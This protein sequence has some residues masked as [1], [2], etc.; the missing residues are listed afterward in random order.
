MSEIKLH[1]GKDHIYLIHHH[2]FK[3]CLLHLDAEKLVCI[4]SADFRAV[5]WAKNI[6]GIVAWSNHSESS[7]WESMLLEIAVHVPYGQNAEISKEGS[8]HINVKKIGAKRSVLK[9]Q[10]IFLR[11]LLELF[12]VF[13]FFSIFSMCRSINS[14]SLS[15]HCVSILR[16]VF[17]S[18]TG[19][20]CNII[21]FC[22]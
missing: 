6:G 14:L 7:C 1:E 9:C 20:M 18:Y 22:L 17:C 11:Q 12:T 3:A 5:F 16:E 10:C 4:Q 21:C 13:D 19:N 15:P 2:I 8:G